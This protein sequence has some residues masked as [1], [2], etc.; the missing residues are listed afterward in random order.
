MV[1]S[2]V[3]QRQTR[4]ALVKRWA[5]GPDEAHKEWLLFPENEIPKNCRQGSSPIVCPWDK[6]QAVG[7]TG[8]RDLR[9]GV[10]HRGH[11]PGQKGM[12]LLQKLGR[13]GLR[14]SSSYDHPS[15]RVIL[16]P[17]CLWCTPRA[18]KGHNRPPR[19]EPE[20]GTP[21]CRLVLT[22]LTQSEPMS[23]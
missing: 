10:L 8:P 2:L 21:V 14:R 5:S 11:H 19:R 18:G 20:L 15:A 16:S 9:D 7:N 13:C 17:R 4:G 23:S 1:A 22:R 12:G 6:P 3:T